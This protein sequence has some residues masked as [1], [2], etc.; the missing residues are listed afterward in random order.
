VTLEKHRLIAERAYLIWERKGC[1][2]GSELDNWVEAEAELGATRAAD[3]RAAADARPAAAPN[4]PA[5]RSRR[6]KQ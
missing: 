3:V 1:P 6:K 2:P 5:K 4:P